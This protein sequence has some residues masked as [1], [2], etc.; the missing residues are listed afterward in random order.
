MKIFI[1]YTK[2]LFKNTI[3]KIWALFLI[4]FGAINIIFPDILAYVL[5]GTCIAVWIGMLL[6]GG[7]GSFGKHKKHEEPYVKFGNYKI[8]R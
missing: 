8:Y 7:K 5:G 1:P 4:A 6:S 3:M 2:L